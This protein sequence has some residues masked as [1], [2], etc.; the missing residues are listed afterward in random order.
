[1][2]C[3]LWIVAF[4]SL[5]GCGPAMPWS[6][7][8]PLV[9]ARAPSMARLRA[10]PGPVG[11]PEGALLDVLYRDKREDGLRVIGVSVDERADDAFATARTLGA[12]FPIVVDRDA[13]LSIAFCISFV[14]DGG[15][16]V[17]FVGL[18]R[19]CSRSR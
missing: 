13:R 2:R 5:A 14:I 8:H 12:S 18:S 9:G 4:I 7:S 15:G 10:E 16:T 17:R 19:S 11:I 1:M 6:L 3:L